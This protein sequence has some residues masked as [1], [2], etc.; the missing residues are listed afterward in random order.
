MKNR[1]SALR[2]VMLDSGIS[3]LILR[4]ID[5]HQT[6]IPAQHFRVRSWASGFSGS[7]GTLLLSSRDAALWTDSRYFVEAE[8]CLENSGIEFRRA[9]SEYDEDM[10]RWIESQTSQGGRIGFYLPS[11]RAIEFC[12]KRL[13]GLS[14]VE[15]AP[16]VAIAWEGR[17]PI[18]FSEIY[19]YSQYS[20]LARSEKLDL[21]RDSMGECNYHLISSMDDI[22]WILNLRGGDLANTP[23]FHSHLLIDRKSAHLFAGDGSLDQSLMEE[24]ASAGVTLNQYDEIYRSLANLPEDSTCLMDPEKLSHQVVSNYRGAKLFGVQPSRSAKVIKPPEELPALREAYRTEGSVLVELLCWIES[25]FH[26]SDSMGKLTESSIADKC[27][28]LRR[29]RSGYKLDSFESIVAF[30]EHAALPHYR[31]SSGGETCIE[32]GGVVL[33]DT[34]AHYLGGST[35]TTRTVYLGDPVPEEI[36]RDYTMVLRAHITLCRLKFP[37]G[38]SGIHLDSIT[39]G[40]MWQQMMNYGHGT[41][42]G[43]GNFLEVHEYPPGVGSDLDRPEVF[44]PIEPG[45]VFSNEPGIYRVGSHG[46]RIECALHVVETGGNEFGEFLS[47]ENLTLVPLDRRLIIPDLCTREELEWIDDYHSRVFSELKET[48]SPESRK[49]LKRQTLPLESSM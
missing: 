17:P 12:A 30:N 6:E 1:V 48:L 13:P 42:H 37:R 25:S 10:F 5:P 34:G 20:H 43:I 23:V 41:G 35:D 2:K 27:I 31:P 47:F 18:E 15:A 32:Q 39:R 8:R 16:Y 14:L 11:V 7:A 3:L 28:S 26:S 21:I 36:A 45:M 46:I 19:S 33:I 38:S 40:V 22:A 24:L 29:K 4:D 49:W 44:V 9:Y